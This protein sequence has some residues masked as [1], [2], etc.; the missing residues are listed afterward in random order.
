MLVASIKGG[1]ASV[2][3]MELCGD[4]LALLVADGLYH[5]PRPNDGPQCTDSSAPAGC[6]QPKRGGREVVSQEIG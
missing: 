1:I 4:R 6:G 5:Q 2:T 3:N